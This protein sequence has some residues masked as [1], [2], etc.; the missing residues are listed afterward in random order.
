MNAHLITAT[1]LFS[2]TML[3]AAESQKALSERA[4]EATAS[5]I[6]L[7]QTEDRKE[8]EKLLAPDTGQNQQRHKATVASVLS[9]LRGHDPKKL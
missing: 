1:L 4:S 5:L 7:A 8:I 3:N 2:L 9:L 6:I